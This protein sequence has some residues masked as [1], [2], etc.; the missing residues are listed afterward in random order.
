MHD[1]EQGRLVEIGDTALWVVERGAADGYPLILLHGGPGDDHHEFGDY[2][3]PLG[4]RYRL[5]LVDQRAQGNSAPADQRTWTLHQMAADVVVLARAMR[6]ERYAVL[7]HSYG[8]FVALQNAVDF[9]GMAA[10]SI[11]SSGL[12]SSR[13]ME[14]VETNLAMFEPLE[15]REQVAASWARETEVNTPEEFAEIL[16]DQMPFH[17]AD[18]LDPRIEEYERQTAGTRFSPP[19]LKAFAAEGYGGIDVEDRLGEI[20]HPVLI[21]HGLRERTCVFEGATA[22]ADAIPNAELVVFEESA[23]MT[24]VEENEKYLVAVRG[25]LDRLTPA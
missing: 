8:A 24:F 12:P 16:R 6:L 1:D 5:L 14:A 17:F 7:G 20:E 9:P 22:M 13:Y 23:H 10:Q 11:I 18:P 19:V 15:L 2:L 4:D 3:D 21:L 25:F